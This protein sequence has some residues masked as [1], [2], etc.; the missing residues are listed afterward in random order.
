MTLSKLSL[1]SMHFMANS[2]RFTLFGLRMSWQYFVPVCTQP[3]FFR[4]R[5]TLLSEKSQLNIFLRRWGA[6]SS[7]FFSISASTK[8]KTSHVTCSTGQPGIGAF[9]RDCRSWKRLNNRLT[10]SRLVRHSSSARILT[11]SEIFLFFNRSLTIFAFCSCVKRP[12]IV[13]CP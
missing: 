5:F 3:S 9:S 1:F 12:M 4:I 2:R 10:L 11:I 6:V 13:E 8:F 7:S